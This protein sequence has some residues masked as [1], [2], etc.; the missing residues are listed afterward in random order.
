MSGADAE[1]LGI[2]IQYDFDTSAFACG[3]GGVGK[4]YAAAIG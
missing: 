2:S 4:I 1:I 3:G